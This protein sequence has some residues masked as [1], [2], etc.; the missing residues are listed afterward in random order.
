MIKFTLMAAGYCTHPEFITI[1][2]GRWRS[3]PFPALFAL[4]EHS[5]AG[6]I[7]FDTGYTGRFF[8]ET[9]RFPASLYARLTPVHFNE[10]EAACRQLQARGFNPGDIRY[11]IISHFHADHIGGLLDF[12]LAQY[13][14]FDEAYGF[15]RSLQGFRA[16]RAGFL[17]GLLPPDFEARSR[18]LPLGR[19]QP[20]PRRYAPFTTGFDLFGDES[21][22][23]VPLPGH[24]PGQLGLFVQTADHGLI[25][26]IADACWQS[27][28]YRDLLWPH[29]LA[30][31]IIAEPQAYRATLQKVH[32][33]HKNNPARP[34]IPSHCLEAL[35]R[36][37]SGG[38]YLDCS[39]TDKDR[40]A[41]PLPA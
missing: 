18:P 39:L 29:P 28:A 11:L 9:R 30:N 27:R 5:Q 41:G 7:L 37:G 38:N 25:F 10:V 36:Y 4:L 13:L 22:V 6:P 14:Y 26:L 35:A 17:P 24:A 16:V 2:G 31:L 12:P 19:L 21:L 34:L 3:V 15:V 23:A 40:R 32:E 1:R 8:S 20:L 33:W